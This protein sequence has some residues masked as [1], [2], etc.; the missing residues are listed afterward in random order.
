MLSRFMLQTKNIVL[1]K[2]VEQ[3]HRML[4][5]TINQGLANFL[6]R[7]ADSPMSG[8]WRAGYSAIYVTG[9]SQC[10]CTA[11]HSRKRGA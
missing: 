3:L 11:V 6:A 1:S 5:D 9:G 8:H 7:G 2:T 4:E 10:C